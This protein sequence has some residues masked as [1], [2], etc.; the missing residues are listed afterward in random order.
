MD[1]HLIQGTLEM[2]IL[3]VLARGH[4]YGYQITQTVLSESKGEF[5]LREG[6]LYPALH[7]LERQKLLSAYWLDSDKG[8]QRKYYKITASGRRMLKKKKQEWTTFAK[9]VQGVLGA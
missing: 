6:S 3:D 8:R 9:A 2:L 7:R 5:E 4:S 1:K